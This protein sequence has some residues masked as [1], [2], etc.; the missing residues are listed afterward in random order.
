MTLIPVCIILLISIMH[1]LCCV[2]TFIVYITS[3]LTVFHVDFA[4]F[5]YFVHGYIICLS[6]I[7]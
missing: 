5:G 2:Y 7:Q 3:L 4:L 1:L 6:I